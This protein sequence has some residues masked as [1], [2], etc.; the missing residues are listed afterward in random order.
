MVVS[1]WITPPAFSPILTAL[2]Y[3]VG[4]LLCSCQIKRPVD[5]PLYKFILYENINITYEIYFLPVNKIS[6]KT[7]ENLLRDSNCSC[8]TTRPTPVMLQNEIYSMS[9][10]N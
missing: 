2:Y 7:K 5:L 10:D 3:I 6:P 1:I 8:C 9:L 4:V